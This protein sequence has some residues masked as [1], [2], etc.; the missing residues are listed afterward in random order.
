LSKDNTRA[1]TAEAHKMLCNVHLSGD[2]HTPTS[3]T[4]I[5]QYVIWMHASDIR[6]EPPALEEVAFLLKQS[7]ATEAASHKPEF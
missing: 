2:L 6:F 7:D 3:G 5:S 4:L 1:K